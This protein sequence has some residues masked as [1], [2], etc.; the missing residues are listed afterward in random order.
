V[1]S[2]GL[3]IRSYGAVHSLDLVVKPVANPDGPEGLF[4]VTFQDAP[5]RDEKLRHPVA[6]SESK[7]V[8]ELNRELMRSRET[9]QATIADQQAFGEEIKSTNEE[10]QSTNEELQ[11]TNEELETSKEELQSINEELVTVNSELQAKVEQLVS[12]QNDMKNL[13]DSTGVGSIFLD[14]NLAIR[15]FNSEATNIFNLIATDTGRPI[16]DITSSVVGVDWVGKARDVLE[17]LVPKEETVEAS[18]GVSYLVRMLPYRTLD[19]VIDGVVLIFINITDRKKAEDNANEMRLYA[20]NIINTVREPLIA[21]DGELKVI[22]ASNSFYKEFRTTQQDTVGRRIYE[23]G[24]RQWDIPR[25]REL[26]EAILPQNTSFDD[27]VVEHDFPEIG[28]KKITLNARR[29]VGKT[30]QTRFIL[31]AMG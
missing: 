30:G 6:Q 28:H 4:V 3:K 12:I 16:G 25:L 26:L 27:F 19:N 14:I 21:L 7:R 17:T 24:N 20:E 2:R 10:L 8:K 5:A 23:I 13:F 1:V 9:I 29:I 18:G 22:S 11:S 15:R 31:L